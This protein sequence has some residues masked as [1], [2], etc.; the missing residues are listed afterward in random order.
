M[1]ALRINVAGL[2]KETA[3]AARDYPIDAPPA[4]LTEL[5]S[6][7][8]DARG[9]APLTGTVRLMRTPQSIFARGRLSGRLAVECSRCLDTAEVPVRFEL[10]AEYF[11]QVDIMTGRGLP[12][13]DDDL[14][15]TINQSHEL[16]LSEAVRQYLILE[17]PMQTVCRE[18][19]QGLCP[20]CGANLN[21]G[22]CACPAEVEDDRLLPLRA[23][24]EKAQSE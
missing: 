1:N 21:S 2:L 6:S 7:E 4:E 10:D 18:A 8:S 14:A 22:A 3:G 13:P 17:L 20:R 19:C 24:L 15:F 9:A 16:D 23:L 5:L 11:P 12:K